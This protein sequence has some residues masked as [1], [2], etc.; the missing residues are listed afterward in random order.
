MFILSAALAS[1]GCADATNG[2]GGS[3]GTAGE[4]GAGTGG[5]A[6]QGGTGTGGTAGQG[7]TGT[8]GTAGQGGAGGQAGIGGLVAYYPFSGNAQDESGNGNDGSTIGGATLAADRS[9]SADSAYQLDGTSGYIEIPDS[10]DFNFNQPI[11]L[12]AWIYLNDNT[13]GGI[14]GQ[15]GPGGVSGDAFV[16]SVRGGKLKFTLPTPGLYELDSQS[17]LAEMQWLFVGVVYDGTDLKLF[18]DGTQ[19][20]SGTFAAAQVD[21]DQPVLI[22]FEQ[23]ISGDPGYLDGLVDDVRIYKRALSDGEIQQLY[24]P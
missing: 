15:W 14:V 23:I 24:Q 2:S 22:G 18:I 19:D 9:G 16:L 17:T 20:A 13:N 4:G 10:A 7:G 5:T 11:T 6:G 3:G 21:S 1:V 8:G 12:T